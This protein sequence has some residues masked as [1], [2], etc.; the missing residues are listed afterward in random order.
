MWG[1][2]EMVDIGWQNK[3]L[4]RV[5]PGQWAPR[6]EGQSENSLPFLQEA[7]SSKSRLLRMKIWAVQEKFPIPASLFEACFHNSWR[8]LYGNV[9]DALRK[10]GQQ[11]GPL[12]YLSLDCNLGSPS[13]QHTHTT[14]LTATLHTLTDTT[15]GI[16]CWVTSK[17]ILT[18][19]RKSFFSWL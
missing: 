4:R 17:K 2:A 12:F 16:H 3:H 10:N 9:H 15:P 1:G 19:F 11:N 5:S 14:V 8:D 18:C 7:E 13:H 6:K